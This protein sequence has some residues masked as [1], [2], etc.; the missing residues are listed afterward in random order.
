MC[1]K[2]ISLVVPKEEQTECCQRYHICDEK[3]PPGQ[4][5]KQSPL[6]DPASADG[7]TLAS[8]E[9][10]SKLSD[11][12]KQLGENRAAVPPNLVSTAKV[13]RFAL[14]P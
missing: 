7:Q 14:C 8:L 3:N 1:Y 12:V 6:A 5:S 13:Q 10:A 2:Q 4:S 9:D 11:S